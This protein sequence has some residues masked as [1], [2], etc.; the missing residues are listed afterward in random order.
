MG[1]INNKLTLVATC[2]FGLESVLRYEIGQIGGENIEVTD[3]RITYQGDEGVLI[4]SNLWLRTAERVLIALG[5]FKATT[6][7]ELFDGVEALPFEDYIGVKDAF[8]VTGWSIDSQL[9]SVPSCQSI[10]KRAIVKRFETVY[11]QKEFE[12]TGVEYQIRFSLHKDEAVIM[13]DTTGEPLYKRGYRANATEAPIRE[14]LAAGIIDLARTRPDDT[15]YD[16]M[17][18]SGTFLIEAAMRAF[19]MAPGLQRN[20]D[21]ENWSV[22]NLALWKEERE[23]AT[24]EANFDADFHGYGYDIDTKALSIAKENAKLAGV[25]EYITFQEQDITEFAPKAPSITVCNPPYGERLLE[26]AEA[27]ELYQSMGAVMPPSKENL[28]YII[29]PQNDFESAFG[30][31]ANRR[32]KLY[33]GMIPCQL[34]MYFRK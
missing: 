32:R 16:P 8:P 18:G 10:I 26:H 29:G 25:A 34:Y 19:S 13:L 20:F 5:S 31:K 12:E 15:V 7:T 17:C 33:N 24:A 3:G 27:L 4:R 30:R 23:K 28:Y 11:G 22:S 6:F 14:T 1:K 2:L 9:H 21:A